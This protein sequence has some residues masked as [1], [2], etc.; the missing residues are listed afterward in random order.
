MPIPFYAYHLTVMTLPP[1]TLRTKRWDEPVDSTD[2]TRLLIT[3]YRPRGVLKADETWA[4][5]LPDLGPSVELH[6]AAYGKGREPIAWATYRST[7]LR[8]MRSQSPAIA[9]LAGRVLT[10]ES[11]TLLCSAQCIRESRCHRSILK[12]LVDAEVARQTSLTHPSAHSSA[13]DG[14]G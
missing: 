13:S 2:G 1:G 14:L 5:W 10:G 7:Y 3:R 4:E 6:A 9:A 8:E 12:E 11:I